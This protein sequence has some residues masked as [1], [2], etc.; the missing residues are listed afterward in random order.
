MGVP[1]VLIV[2]DHEGLRAAQAEALRARGYPVVEAMCAEEVPELTT[3]KRFDLALVDVNLP[4]EDGF[5]LVRRMRNVCPETRVIVTSVRG[6][7]Q[8]K[9]EGYGCGADL[10][11]PKPFELGE[12]LAAIES[13]T[14]RWREEQDLAE[15]SF[16]VLNESHLRLECPSGKGVPLKEREAR[17]LRGL[18]LSRDRTLETW[19]LLEVLEPSASECLE[20][21]KRKLEVVISRLRSKLSRYGLPGA[22]IQAERSVGYRLC[23]ELRLG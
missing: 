10:Y 22:C 21:D 9:C 19:Q 14:R 13:L 15:G 3:T 1:T 12:L 8:D 16:Y 20:S 17:L 7:M 18:A 2:E 5:S 6:G 23:M 11:L 4:A